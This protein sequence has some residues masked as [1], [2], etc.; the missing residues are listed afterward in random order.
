MESYTSPGFCVCSQDCGD[1]LEFRRCRT[2][3]P[4]A[5]VLEQEQLSWPKDQQ[6]PAGRRGQR[7]KDVSREGKS[8]SSGEPPELA[9]EGREPGEA[10]GLQKKRQMGGGRGGRMSRSSCGWERDEGGTP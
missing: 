8:A 2:L 9:R 7:R 10:G 6:H 5:R 4:C 1:T 3:P